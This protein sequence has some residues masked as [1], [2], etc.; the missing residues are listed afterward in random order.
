MQGSSSKLPTRSLRDIHARAD[1]NNIANLATQICNIPPT[2]FLDFLSSE[3]EDTLNLY[4]RCRRRIYIFVSYLYLFL[5]GQISE[6]CALFIT[7]HHLKML[8]CLFAIPH[9]SNYDSL[10]IWAGCH[11]P[12]FL[13]FHAPWRVDRQLKVFFRDTSLPKRCT[14]P[15]IIEPAR[16]HV[17]S[18]EIFFFKTDSFRISHTILTGKANQPIHPVKAVKMY[19]TTRTNTPGPLSR[20]QSA[21]HKDSLTSE[22]KSLLAMSGV[23]P[24][25]YASHSHR[26]G[27][28]TTAASVG[29]PLG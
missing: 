20:H 8:F 29:L 9:T 26:I 16:P 1:F 12:G 10:M 22:T 11:D 28:A 17:H 25:R 7:V 19:L 3:E 2:I 27:A 24:M 23:N 21:P 15:P 13:W 14:L 4:E 6:N 5:L 18:S